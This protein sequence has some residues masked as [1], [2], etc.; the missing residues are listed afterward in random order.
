MEDTCTK[1]IPFV[2]EKYN[3]SA[4][5]TQYKILIKWRNQVRLLEPQEYPLRIA[6]A[7]QKKINQEPL[8]FLQKKL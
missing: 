5:S 2:L 8:F 6:Y 4:D 7:L 1:V 3:M